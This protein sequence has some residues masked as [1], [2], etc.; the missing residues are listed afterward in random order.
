MPSWKL[1]IEYHGAEFR[2]WQRQPGG[3]SVQE[4]LESSLQSLHGGETIVATAAGRTDAGVHARGQVVSIHPLR[5]MK[6]QAYLAGLNSLLPPG[7]AVRDAEPVP[8]D[9]CARRWARGKRY[10]YRVLN[11]RTRSPLR[12]DFTWHVRPP[13]NVEEMR[14]AASLLVGRHP[15]DSFQASGCQARSTVRELWKLDVDREDDEIVFTVEG[16]AFLRHMIR[17]LVGTL[18]EVGVGRRPASSMTSLLESRDRTRAGRTAAPQGLCLD[19]VFYDLE[20]GPPVRERRGSGLDSEGM[21]EWDD[22]D[23]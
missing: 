21:E 15:F 2:G 20:S 7:I 6:E 17:N 14:K 4:V 10:V 1:T 18:V 12:A 22:D 16:D 9:F 23:G 3:L 8:A 19:E 5:H 13:L 11:S